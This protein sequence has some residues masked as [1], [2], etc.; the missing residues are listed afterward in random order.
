MLRN[1]HRS[2]RR[3]SASE[4][5]D[6]QIDKREKSAHALQLTTPSNSPHF[7]SG[8]QS[9]NTCSERL[10]Q[11]AEHGNYRHQRANDV[12]WGGQMAERLYSHIEDINSWEV[13]LHSSAWPH[14][15]GRFRGKQRFVFT[16]KPL[17]PLGFKSP[18]SFEAVSSLHRLSPLPFL[19]FFHFASKDLLIL[20]LCNSPL[21]TGESSLVPRGLDWILG[22]SI[23]A[24]EGFT[25][26]FSFIKSLNPRYTQWLWP[27]FFLSWSKPDFSSWQRRPQS[28]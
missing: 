27:V 12:T 21:I 2:V 9:V 5:K 10:Q 15:E 11:K 6:G 24:A 8:I 14:G 17:K 22:S 3:Y 26:C 19:F 20:H 1:A 18:L 25:L 4:N 7:L 23:W 28:D 16:T 13:S